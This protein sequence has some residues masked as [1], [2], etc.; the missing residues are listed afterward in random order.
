MALD[1]PL[2]G[3]GPDNLLTC[4]APITS[5]PAHG[6]N[7]TSAIHTT[8]CSTC[9]RDWAWLGIAPRGSRGAWAPGLVWDVAPVQAGV[10]DVW[11]IGLGLLAG[12]AATVSH[13]LI[14][15]SLF[16]TDLMAL[17]VLALGLAGGCGFGG[18]SLARAASATGAEEGKA[19]ANR[20]P[21]I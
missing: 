4:T 12:L 10:P 6:R 16:L 2:L 13:G 8:S 1:H 15:N 3:V 19:A 17:F 20:G 9:G 21:R 11:P 14:D 7:S 18:K 5:C